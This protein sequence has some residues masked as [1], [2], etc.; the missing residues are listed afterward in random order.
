LFEEQQRDMLGYLQVLQQS[1]CRLGDIQNF[2]DVEKEGLL[3]G[4]EKAAF[5]AFPGK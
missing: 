3:D 5:H 2:V 4:G 1:K